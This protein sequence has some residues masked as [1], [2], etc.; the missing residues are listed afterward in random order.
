MGVRG[1]LDIHVW[2]DDMIGPPPAPAPEREQL[3]APADAGTEGQ[4]SAASDASTAD[5]VAT[6][7][8]TAEKEMPPGSI[9]L[10]LAA[11]RDDQAARSE[12]RRIQ[13]RH[14]Q[15]LGA[16]AAHFERVD[17][18]GKGMF[19]RIQAGPFASAAAAES[20]CANLKAAGQGCFVVRR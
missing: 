14:S 6:A 2:F 12:W 10:Q 5:A 16:M 7:S 13:G 20:A 19:T 11:L 18:P 17:I 1:N 3:L 9:L 8:A 4:D 15:V